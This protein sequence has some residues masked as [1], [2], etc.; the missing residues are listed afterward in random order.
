MKNTQYDEVI[1]TGA[2]CDCRAMIRE[3]NLSENYYPLD[4]LAVYDN[5]K[6]I[7]IIENDLKNLFSDVSLD[8]LKNIDGKNFCVY[9]KINKVSSIHDVNH[10]GNLHLAIEQI[11]NT[12]EYVEFKDKM[13]RRTKRWTEIL[14]DEKKRILFIRMELFSISTNNFIN[15]LYSVLKR[16]HQNMEF[17]YVYNKT[18]QKD[19]DL[20]TNNNIV[21]IPVSM[22]KFGE[23]QKDMAYLNYIRTHHNPLYTLKED[24][25]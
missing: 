19:A 3:F 22:C 11:K 17:H 13:T 15:N 4:W 8:D 12:P 16:K 25:E 14:S 21:K 2:S 5:D 24:N 18:K 9:D 10:N 1:S 7:E 20:I 23:C 6:L